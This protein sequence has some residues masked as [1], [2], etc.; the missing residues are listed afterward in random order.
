MEPQKSNSAAF[1]V[2]FVDILFF[3]FEVTPQRHMKRRGFLYEIPK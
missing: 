2:F 3:F 1:C